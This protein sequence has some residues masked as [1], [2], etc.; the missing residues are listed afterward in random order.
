MPSPLLAGEVYYVTST[1]LTETEFAISTQRYGSALS[2]TTNGT[3]QHTVTLEGL[4]LTALRENYNYVDLTMW[5]PGEF[6]TSGSPCTISIGSPATI[7]LPGHSFVA[8]DVVKFETTGQLPTG[9]SKLYNYHVLS[10][11]LVPGTSFQV[12]LAPGG[13]PADTSGVQ[14]GTHTVGLVTGRVGDLSFAVNPVGPNDISRVGGSKFVFKGEEYVIAN[15]APETVTNKPYARVTLDRPLEDSLIAYG[16]SYTIKAGVAKRTSGSLGTLTI[17]I[18]LTRVTSHDLLEIGTG[19]Y[20]D[21]NYPKEIYGQSVNALNEDTETDERDVGRCFYVT[22][23]QYGNFKVGPYF[24]VDQGTGTVTFSSSIALSNL[25]GIGFKRGV[26]VSEFSTDSGFTDN[27][28]DTVP[29]E[30]ATRIYIERRLGITHDGAK[31]LSEQLIPTVTGGFM[32]LDGQL[33]MKNSMDL[34]GNKILR[35]GDATD[36][37]DAI[38]LR[39]LTWDNFQDFTP[40]NIDA[41]DILVFTGAA[42]SSVNATVVGDVTFELRPGVDSTINQVDVQL[43]PDTII[44]ADVKSDADIAQSKLLM[45]LTS[46]RSSAPTG[47]ARDKQ[48]ASGVASFDSGVFTV[49]DGWVTL[50]NNGGSLESLQQIGPKKVLGN[51]SLTTNNVTQ[52][53]FSTVVNDGGAIKKNQFTSTGFLRRVTSNSNSADADYTIVEAAT[54]SATSV[55]ASKLIIRDAN[56]DFGGRVANIS[57]LKIDNSISVDS[58]VTSTGGYIRYYGY[59]GAGGIIVQSGSL[60]TDKITYYDN[61]VHQFR[62]QTGLSLGS[63]RTAQLEATLLTTGGPTTNGTITGYWSLSAGSRLQATYSAD[64]AEYYEGDKEYEVGTVLVFGGDKEVTT[65]NTRGDTRVAGVVSDNAA[66]TMYG[67]CPGLKNLVALQGRVPCKVVGKI[68]KG[69]IL[70]TAGIHGVAVS[71]TGDVKVGTVV[72]KAL[73]DYD[74]DHIGTIEIAVG[75]T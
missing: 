23:D 3:G 57:Q 72:G 8:G 67:A 75:R 35:I 58:D 21:T 55:E 38:N 20:A 66:Y 5:Q 26:P 50:K 33:A 52:V 24:K 69:D 40:N 62:N 65:S 32:A 43:V 31:V 36:P 53:D 74:S 17:R 11:G 1:N 71:A 27:A 12:S 39:S 15:Y 42:N 2:L 19:S 48:A 28:T 30:N 56:G 9:I 7:T 45:N 51:A 68:K 60:T 6:V 22:T 54:G 61:D 10:D 41:A 37:Q 18:A 63:I 25:D 13:F 34:D 47:S 46:T 14:N 59:N 64:L 70:T 44:D 73:Q 49:T 29:T 4:T 16:S